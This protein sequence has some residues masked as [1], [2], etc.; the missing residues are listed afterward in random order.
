VTEMRD[1][2][3]ELDPKNLAKVYHDGLQRREESLYHV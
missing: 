3:N 2:I 1:I